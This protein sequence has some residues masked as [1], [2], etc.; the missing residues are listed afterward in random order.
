MA[1]GGLITLLLAAQ[2]KQFN[3]AVRDSTGVLKKFGLGTKNVTGLVSRFAGAFTAYEV[4]SDAAR[5]VVEFDAAMVGLSAILGVTRE[6]MAALEEQAKSLGGTTIFTAGQIGKMQTTLARFG[7]DESEILASSEAIADL[8]AAASIELTQASDIGASTLRAFN[9]EAK[10][11]G[12]VADV[13]A[14]AFTKSALDVESFAQ[15]MVYAAPI[16]AAAGTEI[17]ETSAM[18]AILADN[19]IRGSIAGT[20][21]RRIFTELAGQGKTLSQVFQETGGN[22]EYIADAMGFADDAVGKYA[23]SAFLV[24]AENASNIEAVTEEM[25]EFGTASAVAAQ[26][27]SSLENQTKLFVSAW[28]KF[29]TN[30]DSGDGIFS[31]LYKEFLAYGTLLFDGL[32]EGINK[33]KEFISARDEALS[34]GSSSS[35]NPYSLAGLL[36]LRRKTEQ[37]KEQALPALFNFLGDG[38]VSSSLREYEAATTGISKMQEQFNKEILE[39]ALKTSDKKRERDKE[40]AKLQKKYAE[41]Y[42][43]QLLEEKALVESIFYTYDEL[44]KRYEKHTQLRYD[45]LLNTDQMIDARVT[46]DSFFKDNQLQGL[47]DTPMRTEIIATPTVIDNTESLIKANEELASSYE[48]MASRIA[49]ALSQSAQSWEE[50]KNNL[51]SSLIAIVKQ[52]AITTAI[53][54]A[55]AAIRDSASVPF[56]LIAAPAAV[57]AVLAMVET[58][59]NK[60]K[61][62][63][64]TAFAD[65][66]IV[67]SPVRALVGEYSG[68]STN[69]EIIAPLS[70]LKKYLPDGGSGEVNVTGEFMLRNSVLVA[71]ID[72]ENSRRSKYGGR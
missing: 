41:A 55:S 15:A 6:E 35:Y 19:G 10:E 2:T 42:H 21:L 32:G 22:A 58:S 12:R 14:N 52:L 69:P 67:K 30:V 71:A 16:A 3:K 46:A 63:G 56:G 38:D 51:L 45:K 57:A 62:T 64:T 59:L 40:D 29:I 4:L 54:A 31:S 13:M 66:G 68:V 43:E 70:D 36:E 53:E 20:S 1:A 23:L 60:A 26:Q 72:R 17:E 47:E 34:D 27:L 25:G 37:K 48:T 39:G 50:Y 5:R 65:G 7:F 11:M 49:G 28:E 61:Q 44:N 24:L 8:A 33:L 9:L 18:L